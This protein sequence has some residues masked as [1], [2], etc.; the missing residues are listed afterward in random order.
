MLLFVAVA[1]SPLQVQA[2]N[3]PPGAIFDLATSLENP[4]AL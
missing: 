2:Q 3:P 4:G 1:L